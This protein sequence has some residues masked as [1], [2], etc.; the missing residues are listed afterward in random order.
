MLAPTWAATTID[1]VPAHAGTHTPRLLLF[2]PWS[3]ALAAIDIGGYGSLL[4][5]F[6]KASSA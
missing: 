4:A 5:A 2:A 3:A 1:V 6:A